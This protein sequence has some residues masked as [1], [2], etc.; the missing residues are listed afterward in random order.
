MSFKYIL[1]G[2]MILVFLTLSSCAVYTGFEPAYPY[3]HVYYN[4]LY[5]GHDHYYD[6]EH[7]YDYDRRHDHDHHDDYDHHHDYDSDHND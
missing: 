4:G 6:H 2:I 5:N 3:D 7:Y 1:T